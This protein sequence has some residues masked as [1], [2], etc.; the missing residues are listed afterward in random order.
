MKGIA[1]IAKPQLNTWVP[2]TSTIAGLSLAE[3]ITSASLR[4]ALGLATVATT[5]SYNDLLD[6]PSPV[7]ANWGQA[8]PNAAD[9]ILGKPNLGDYQT[10]AAMAG[11]IQAG[12]A[13]NNT[14]YPSVL[15]VI[16]YAMSLAGGQFTGI[17]KALNSNTPTVSQLRNIRFIEGD[18]SSLPNDAVDGEIVAL[19]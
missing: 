2:L 1:K 18:S 6:K 7:R 15:S 13:T 4:A 10:K 9:F 5:G 14:T 12:V 3:S 16:N 17:V 11:T 19:Y 8:N